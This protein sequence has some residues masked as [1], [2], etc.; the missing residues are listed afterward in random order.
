MD[1]KSAILNKKTFPFLS[2]CLTFDKQ[3]IQP[4]KKD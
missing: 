2:Y 3:G 1:E 4:E